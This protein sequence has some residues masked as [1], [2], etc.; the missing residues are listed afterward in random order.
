MRARVRLDVDQGSPAD[1]VATYSGNALRSNPAGGSESCF[2]KEIADHVA[3]LGS[4]HQRRQD[5]ANV[6]ELALRSSGMDSVGLYLFDEHLHATEGVILGMPDAFSRAYEV[7]GMRIDPVLAD[8]RERGLPSS[9]VTCLGERWTRSEL[10]KRVSGRYGLTGF[11]TL[12]LYDHDRLAGVLYLGT[13]HEKPLPQLSL[14]GLFTMSP[15]ATRI[16]TRLL[17][18]PKRAPHLTPRQND[19]A[20]L[21]AE[22]LSNRDIAEALDTG[23]AAVRKHL[24]ALNRHFATTN[25]TAMSAAWRA[26][27]R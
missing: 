7:T 27:A 20:R 12:P 18:L 16:S 4:D 23:E 8:V 5:L 25:R 13:K 15:H 10:Y 11:A 19:V 22:G 1:L 21:A 6:A 17:S 2:F 24:K 26:A 14:E 9:T 3:M